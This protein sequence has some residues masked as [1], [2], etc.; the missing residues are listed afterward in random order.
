MLRLMISVLFCWAASQAAWAQER[1][2]ARMSYAV[3]AAGLNVMVIDARAILGPD[4]YR[5]DVGYHTTGLFGMLMPARIDSF[6]QGVWAGGMPAPVRYASWGM[7]RGQERRATLDYVDGH[8]VVTTLEPS[9]DGEHERVPPALREGFDSLSAM[10]YLVR[11]VAESGACDGDL[12]LFDG[13]RAME[14]TS[15][16]GGTEKLAP[17]YRSEFS[18]EALRCNFVGRQLA[19]FSRDVD[20]KERTRTHESQAWL[21]RVVPGEPA[22]PV[23]IS[24]ETRFFGHATA[25]LTEVRTVPPK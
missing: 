24:F 18:G 1:L 14:I 17:D 12:R 13:R 6:V 15:R 10:A 21:A 2:A 16:T 9:D 3:Y 8:P 11:R 7:V 4:G 23:R 19:G 25:F 22:L 5:V 20:A